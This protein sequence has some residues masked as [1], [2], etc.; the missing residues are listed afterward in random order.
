VDREVSTNQ[1][2]LTAPSSVDDTHAPSPSSRPRSR[3]GPLIVFVGG[4][5][6]M[7]SIY[8]GDSGWLKPIAGVPGNDSFYHIKMASLM[9]QVGLLHEFPWLRFCYFTDQGQAFISHHYGFHALL[10]PFV[11]LSQWLT[12]DELPGGRWAICT[13]FGLVLVFLDRLLV[14]ARTPWRWLWLALFV[15]LPFQFFT[16]HAFIRAITPS[17]VL[18]LLILL[19]MFRRRYVWTAFAVAVYVHLYMGGVIFGP[20][21]VGLY[22]VAMLIVPP[23]D[24]RNPWR[25]AVWVVAGWTIG[26][27]THPYRDGM[28]E[29]LR[30]Q[31]FGTG[32]SPDIAVG[33]EWKP[34]N[35]LWW[36][37]QMSGIMLGVWA[38]AVL[39][40]LRL[41][42]PANAEELA[43]FLIN[44]AFLV[45]TLK[46]RRF[47]EYWPMFCML[48]AAYLAAPV[49]VNL[50][51]IFQR[52]AKSRAIYWFAKW[53]PSAAVIGVIV[54][55]VF[56]PVWQE[57]RKTS[58][59]EYDLPAIRAAMDYLQEQS[60]PGEVVFTD[61]WDIFPVYFFYNSHNHYV[62]GL[63]PKFTHARR[64]DL[65]ERYVKITRGQIPSDVTLDIPGNDAK[66]VR[67][68]LHVSL[69]DI[70][71]HFGANY[72]VTDRDH[73]PLAKKLAEAK[74]FTELIYPSTSYAKSRDA[75]YL[76]FRVRGER[77]TPP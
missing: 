34:Y 15:L 12:G 27:A 68:P 17:L 18:M 31:V 24:G 9:P 52:R 63:D 54:I 40:R 19:L 39:A 73:K 37:A 50:T 59:C 43:L 13:F 14:I 1:P 61:D 4:V 11:K 29:F 47:I 56:S 60:Q 45:L 65:W 46:S 38:T 71:E 64:P 66:V 7:H 28:W 58:Q 2:P 6:L 21:I 10:V 53:G 36:F 44:F 5:V 42:K 25:L 33:K 72:V 49:I 48:S 51:E 41:G 57:I 77:S 16:R 62:V 32:L 20:L 70:R 8:A 3:L 69:E 35:D 67:Q 23:K 26:I 30:L 75:P 55:M 76:I 22:V 74:D